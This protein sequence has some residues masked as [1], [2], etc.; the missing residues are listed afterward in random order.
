MGLDGQIFLIRCCRRAI[1]KVNN[2]LHDFIIINMFI[3]RC[4]RKWAIIKE[5]RIARE[6]SR[7]EPV[8][9][10][11]TSLENNLDYFFGWSLSFFLVNL[12]SNNWQGV[13]CF[14]NLTCD[15]SFVIDIGHLENIVF[16]FIIY[17]DFYD[18][19]P[20]NVNK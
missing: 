12:S 2:P 16:L 13:D 20:K 3:V 1:I 19:Y 17:L 11:E 4:Y 15:K 5:T 6:G 14:V 10:R 9:P 18:T 8:D 7:E